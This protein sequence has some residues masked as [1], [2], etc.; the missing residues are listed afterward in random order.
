MNRLILTSFALLMLSATA[1][2]ASAAAI[3]TWT[4]HG[5][6]GTNGSIEQ[7]NTATGITTTVTSAPGRPDSVLVLSN[8]D[9]LYTVNMNTSTKGIVIFNGVS[10]S[11]TFPVGSQMSG[12]VRQLALSPSGS[13]VSVGN[14]ADGSIYN[15]NLTTDAVTT[16]ATG[17]GTVDGLTYGSDGN[18][19][20]VTE[21]RTAV[22][23]LNPVTGAIIN[24]VTG[25]DG[26]LVGMTF[27]P[28]TGQ[29][30]VADQVTNGLLELSLGLPNSGTEIAA[31]QFNR[32]V[33]LFYDGLG[34]IY[35]A[36]F[37]TNIVE[38]NIA[39]DTT[40]V[41]IPNAPGANNLFVQPV[42]E[43]NSL[44]LVAAGFLGLT[45]IRERRRGRR[46]RGIV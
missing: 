35:A 21:N 43:P 45:F 1:S 20:A 10:N 24:S 37:G 5:A 15:F 33:G 9:F 44:A 42:S 6:A 34:D 26:G 38:Y 39:S 2:S 8:G 12:G 32:P 40:S 28:S 3:I 11:T 41:V 29:L 7:T 19:Y 46:R 14:F 25:L 4:N 30:F 36:N 13:Y 27:D 16:L 22:D 23:E 18:L 17:L 31:G